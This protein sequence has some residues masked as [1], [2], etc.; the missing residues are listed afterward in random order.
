MMQ[1]L[2][3]FAE[4][5]GEGFLADRITRSE[6][7]LLATEYAQDMLKGRYIVLTGRMCNNPL[8]CLIRY[9]RFLKW[10]RITY[11][12]QKFESES[13]AKDF[14]V[15]KLKEL[16]T[17]TGDWKLFFRWLQKETLSD[18]SQMLYG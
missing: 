15:K 3:E 9:N 12:N 2:D 5:I 14:L 16:L 1:R 10:I 8:R 17:C 4:I 18:V 6:D 7:C 11:G 13:Q